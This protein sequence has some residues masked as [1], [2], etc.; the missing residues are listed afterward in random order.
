MDDPG[1]DRAPA[2]KVSGGAILLYWIPLGAG[3][4]VVRRSGRLFERLSARVQGR[5]VCDLYHFALEVT[6]GPDRFTIEMAPIPARAD[7]D[8]G[9]VCEGPVGTRW[10]GW[11]RV[12]RYEV[13]CWKDGTIPDARAATNGPFLVDGDSHVA[14]QLIGLTPSVPAPVWGRDELEAGEMWN[15]NSVTSWLL[16]SAGV[17]VGR[18]RPPS[19]G[20]APGWD[21]G[22]TVARR[23]H[24]AAATT[25]V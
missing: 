2:P 18:L 14:E 10:L 16:A 25:S 22:I 3:A 4:D 19:G 17:D 6:V 13:R 20:R 23:T 7:S 15:S 1:T 11:L 9:V 5:S 8:R 24:L 21:A 12:F